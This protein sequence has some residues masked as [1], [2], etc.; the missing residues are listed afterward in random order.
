[1]S[2]G[3]GFEARVGALIGALLA[4]TGRV[5]AHGG[6]QGHAGGSGWSEVALGLALVVGGVLILGT[7]VYLDHAGELDGRWADGGVLLGIVGLLA[8]IALSLL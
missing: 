3:T 2:P 4:A 7:S 6:H 5:A 1:M 8:G